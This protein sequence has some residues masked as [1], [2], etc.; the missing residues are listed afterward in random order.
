MCENPVTRVRTGLPRGYALKRGPAPTYRW[1][2]VCIEPTEYCLPDPDS[3][4]DYLSFATVEEG[5]AWFAAH[6]A[7]PAEAMPEVTGR[8]ATFAAS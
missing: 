3:R 6:V 7:R 2:A 1:Y 5:Q 4:G 8:A